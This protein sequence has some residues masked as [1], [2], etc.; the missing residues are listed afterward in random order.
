[1]LVNGKSLLDDSFRSRRKVLHRMFKVQEGYFDFVAAKDFD[2]FST[3]PGNQDSSASAESYEDS[4]STTHQV[5]VQEL[6]AWMQSS[7]SASCEGLV[8]KL[9][10]SSET[11]E[12]TY[13]VNK[14]TSSW[15]K[16]KQDYLSDVGGGSI[17]KLLGGG[18]A[19]TLDLVV[20]GAWRGSGRKSA[21]WS[22]FLLACWDPIEQELQT[23]CKCMS[24]FSDEFYKSMNTFFAGT[25]EQGAPRTLQQKQFEVNRGQLSHEPTWF[26]ATQVWEIRGAE[27]TVSPTY[28][29]AQGLL[30]NTDQGLSLRFPRFIRVREDKKPEDATTSEALAQM[31]LAQTRR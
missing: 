16:L 21:W 30:P 15:L 28:A 10:D 24:G 11:V 17:P 3:D 6:M 19:D 1:M 4:L 27:L 18:L 9:L 5:P 8:A 25:T 26:L 12:A 13:E 23:L 31:Y 22:P 14:R 20:V 7:L 29:A 2:T